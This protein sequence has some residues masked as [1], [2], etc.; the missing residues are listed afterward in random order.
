[1]Y[2]KNRYSKVPEEVVRNP[3]SGVKEQNCQIQ[4]LGNQLWSSAK[5]QGPSYQFSLKTVSQF[6]ALADLEVVM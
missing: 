2:A 3:A 4:M 1:V 6:G 5:Q